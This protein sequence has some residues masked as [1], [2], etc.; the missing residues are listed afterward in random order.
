MVNEPSVF[1]PLKFYCICHVDFPIGSNSVD[2]DQTPRVSASDLGLRSLPTFLL[3]GAR[4]KEVKDY[5]CEKRIRTCLFVNSD[6]E[7]LGGCKDGGG[8]PCVDSSLG[9]V[10]SGSFLHGTCVLASE[11]VPSEGFGSGICRTCMS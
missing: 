10:D 4:Y 11:Q 7:K 6:G 3:W 1:E 8:T 9:C 2:S 5:N